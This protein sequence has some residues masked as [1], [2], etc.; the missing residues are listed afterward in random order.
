MGADANS[1]AFQIGT[2]EI[3]DVFDNNRVLITWTAQTGG[4]NTSWLYTHIAQSPTHVTVWFIP[5]MSDPS[6]PSNW[7][8]MK[9][10]NHVP[11]D[12]FVGWLAR[13]V[14]HAL[15]VEYP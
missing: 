8:Q 3:R 10:V 11:G 2:F 6:N 5:T 13:N 9:I 15:E 14:C 12:P 7:I 4:G 1:G